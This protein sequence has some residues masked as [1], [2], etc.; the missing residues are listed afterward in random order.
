MRTTINLFIIGC[1]SVAI[2]GFSSAQ[3]LSNVFEN[4]QPTVVSSPDDLPSLGGMYAEL[5]NGQRMIVGTGCWGI[6]KTEDAA[7]ADV[8]AERAAVLAAR[9]ELA[10]FL[11]DEID[12]YEELLYGEK[13][14]GQTLAIR[15]KAKE[16]IRG[17][18]TLHSKSL[19]GKYCATV[20]FSPN[21]VAVANAAQQEF[22]LP[23]AGLN[24]GNVVNRPADNAQAKDKEWVSP[25]FRQ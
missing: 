2:T 18:E 11:E 23:R 4:T 9:G 13:G 22:D 17:A 19:N 1:V 8:L 21:T 7:L 14:A 25:A 20:G 12:K 16:T 5:P 3:S 15:T 24:V 6:D 10:V